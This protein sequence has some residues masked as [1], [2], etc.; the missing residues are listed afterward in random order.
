[1][2][3]SAIPAITLAGAG[4]GA[5]PEEREEGQQVVQAVVVQGGAGP[6]HRPPHPAAPLPQ[7]LA[8][9]HSLQ[10]CHNV[11]GPGASVPAAGQVHLSALGQ[12]ATMSR[13]AGPLSP[14]TR[15][16]RGR[17]QLVQAS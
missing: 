11:L 3:A 13:V 8:G 14:G 15:C 12:A 5:A 7:L 4:C 6:Q 10:H 2:S 17:G 1:M 16:D 9:R